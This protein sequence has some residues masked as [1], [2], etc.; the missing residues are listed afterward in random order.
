MSAIIGAENRIVKLRHV[1]VD[2]IESFQIMNFAVS[3][4]NFI[5]LTLN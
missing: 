2:V 1:A 3:P 5:Q 4:E